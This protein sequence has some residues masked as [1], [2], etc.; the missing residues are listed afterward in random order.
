MGIGISNGDNTHFYAEWISEDTS[1]DDDT[2]PFIEQG[3]FRI[4]RLHSTH[5]D[6]VITP[7]EFS[8]LFE[9]IDLSRSRRLPRWNPTPR[10][11]QESVSTS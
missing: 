2:A 3:C 10:G 1:W 5:R 8:A 6:A 4:P 11:S 9:G 7:A